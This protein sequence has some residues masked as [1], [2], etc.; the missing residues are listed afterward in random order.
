[1]S[2]KVQSVFKELKHSVPWVTLSSPK[3]KDFQSYLGTYLKY[4]SM[5]MYL[6]TLPSLPL[7]QREIKVHSVL[8][9]SLVPI[10]EQLSLWGS[11]LIQ[12]A[13]GVQV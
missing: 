12:L 6:G 7:L 13:F 9:V 10:I 5:Y 1:M 8:N 2:N 11:M 3:E 4:Q